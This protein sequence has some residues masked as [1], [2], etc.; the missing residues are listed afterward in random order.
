MKS[1]VTLLRFRFVGRRFAGF[2]TTKF[3]TSPPVHGKGASVSSSS[4]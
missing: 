1:E 2:A 3:G 4:Q